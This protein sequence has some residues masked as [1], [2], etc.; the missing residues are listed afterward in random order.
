MDRFLENFFYFLTM[1]IGIIIGVPLA[2]ILIMVLYIVILE[3]VNK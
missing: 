2:G 3:L 1:T